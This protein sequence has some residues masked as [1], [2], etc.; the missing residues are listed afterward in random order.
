MRVGCHLRAEHSS[1]LDS[2]S[3]KDFRD[4]A[5]SLTERALTATG[6]GGAR[7]QVSTVVLAYDA[8]NESSSGVE[9]CV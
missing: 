6:I 9:T 2:T 7:A 1:T 4:V 3:A 5:V 8:Y